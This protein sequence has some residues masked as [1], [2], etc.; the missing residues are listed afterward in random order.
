MIFGEIPFYFICLGIKYRLPITNF[1]ESK[2]PG[3][4]ISY[5]LS[6]RGA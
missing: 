2:Y 4:F 1:Y 6:N 5:I 3:R